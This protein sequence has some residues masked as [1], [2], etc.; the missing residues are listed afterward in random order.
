MKNDH[1]LVAIVLV[2]IVFLILNWY[3]LP[4]MEST[5]PKTPAIIIKMD[6]ETVKRIDARLDEINRVLTINGLIPAK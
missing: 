2:G 5:P 6:Y 3:A 1:W 4:K